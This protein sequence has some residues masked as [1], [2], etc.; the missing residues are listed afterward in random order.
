MLFLSFFWIFPIFPV[1]GDGKKRKKPVEKL[2]KKNVFFPIVKTLHIY[3]SIAEIEQN[4]SGN[5]LS[6]KINTHDWTKLVF[7]NRFI[8]CTVYLILFSLKC[9]NTTSAAVK[10]SPNFIFQAFYNLDTKRES[11]TRGVTWSNFKLRTASLIL[12]RLGE[13][14]Y[15]LR[16]RQTIFAQE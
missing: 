14:K 3:N 7:E 15:K 5:S 9:L 10:F 8:V 6:I 4:P 16:F 2:K 1:F 13:M 12:H 11:R